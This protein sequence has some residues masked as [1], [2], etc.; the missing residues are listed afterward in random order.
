[1]YQLELWQCSSFSKDTRFYHLELCQDIFGNWVIKRTWGSAVQRD[2]GRSNSI[3]CPDYQ[4][5]LLWYEKQQ[6][7][8]KKRGY[9][10]NKG[11]A[12]QPFR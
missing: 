12:P 9:R 6:T 11:A 4:T 7:R 10:V 1:M 3:I 5:G 2:F 8:R